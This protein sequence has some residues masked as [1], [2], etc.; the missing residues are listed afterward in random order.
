MKKAVATVYCCF[1]SSV[2]AF[3]QDTGPTKV[4]DQAFV[5]FA[6]QNDMN[7]AHLG[8][9]AADHASSQAVKDFAQML[10]NDHKKD[11][12]QLSTFGRKAGLDVPTSLDASHLKLIAPLEKL[13]GPAF[14]RRF[15]HEIVAGHETATAAYDKESRDG[16]NPELKAYAKDTVQL[17]EKHK[18]EAKLLLKSAK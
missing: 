16:T 11:Y 15:I 17:L 10:V 8:E 7:E 14:D 5:T 4:S 12:Q 2:L 1:L 3:A 6:A 13:K 18:D 9:L